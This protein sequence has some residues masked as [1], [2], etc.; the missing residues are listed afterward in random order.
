MEMVIDL[1]IDFDLNGQKWQSFNIRGRGYEFSTMHSNEIIAYNLKILSCYETN[2]TVR[3]IQTLKY[4][5]FLFL[6][7]TIEKS[8][9][10][11]S[12]IFSKYFTFVK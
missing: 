5:F 10:R 1:D 11:D 7:Y 8:N 2:V 4:M 9:T 12:V 3:N 6:N